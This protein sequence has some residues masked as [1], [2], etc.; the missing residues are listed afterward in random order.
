MPALNAAK[1][2]SSASPANRYAGY[3]AALRQVAPIGVLA[4]TMIA[5]V[6]FIR[7]HV[8]ALDFRHAFW[9]AGNQLLHGASPYVDANSRDVL[10]D[11]AFAYPAVAALVFAPFALIPHAA[12]DGIFTALFITGIAVAMRAAGVRDRCVFALV[13]FSAPVV[14]GWQTANLSLLLCLGLAGLWRWRDRPAA[15]GVI[16]ALL[17]S[18]KIFLWPLG[19]WLLATRR[20]AGFGYA[21]ASGVAMNGLAWT[22]LG[23]DQLRR[24]NDLVAVLAKH[25]EGRGYSPIAIALHH[26]ADRFWAYGLGLTLAAVAALGCL[27]LARRGRES[28]ALALCVAASL[29]ATPVLWPHYSVL[30]IVPLALARPRLGWIWAAPLAMWVCPA[31]DPATWQALVGLTVGSLMVAAAVRPPRNVAAEV[32]TKLTGKKGTVSFKVPR[33]EGTVVIKASAKDCQTITRHPK[34]C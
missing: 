20:Y 4:F 31:T 17:V 6:V 24:Y 12:A 9:P 5:A 18:V 14:V 11:A 15:A 33:R 8:F 21:L 3:A 2:P 16:L 32:A 25:Q 29:L 30:L 26:G 1:T 34:V 22:V 7:A 13:F 27:A 28:A 19:L 10:R 23:W